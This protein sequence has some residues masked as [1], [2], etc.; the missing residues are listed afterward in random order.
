M[1]SMAKFTRIKETHPETLKQLNSISDYKL[2][3]LK[4]DNV[5]KNI[6]EL[7]RLIDKLYN[8]DTEYTQLQ[9]EIKSLSEYIT[10][11]IEKLND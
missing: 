8:M 3:S 2:K 1:I 9:G 5:L 7:D 6:R 11:E 10:N 4:K